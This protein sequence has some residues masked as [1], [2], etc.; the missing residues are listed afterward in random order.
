[1][2]R[3][4]LRHGSSFLNPLKKG[5]IS[6]GLAREERAPSKRAGD[7]QMVDDGI[8]RGGPKG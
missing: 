6:A 5:S 2:E 7:L 8:I 1:M 4:A 3:P